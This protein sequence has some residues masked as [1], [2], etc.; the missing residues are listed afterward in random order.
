MSHLEHVYGVI[1]A[2]GGGTRL[3]P[4]SRNASPKQFLKLMGKESMMQV[5]AARLTHLL[6][7]DHII[8]VTNK[9]Y[10]EEVRRELPE[11]PA[12]NIISEPEKRETALAMLVGT[13][14]AKRLD[15]EAV[16]INS[17]S[18]HVVVNQEEF[19]KV[20]EAAVENARDGQHLLTVGIQPTSPAT[21]FGYIRRGEKLHDSSNGVPVYKVDSFKE[22]PDADTAKQFVD[23]GEYYWNANMYVWSATALQAGF[24]KHMPELYQLTENLVNLDH[25]AFHAA[26][27]AIYEKSPSIAID[28]A[29]SEKA[30]NLL[31]FFFFFGWND[32]GDWKVVYELGQKD[33]SD[34]VVIN[35]GDGLPSISL[36]AHGNLVHSDGRLVSLIGVEDLL[37]IDT[38]E[39]LLIMPKSRSQEVKKIVEQLKKDGQ[40][41]YL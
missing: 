29:I 23:T 1:L 27:P 21:S 10:T 39:I 8:V 18:D 28:Y 13:L 3:W 7:W 40:Q 35:E 34:N 38:K 20:M 2:G 25:E 5:A 19:V 33:E 14:F 32:V 37:V 41:K 22:K 4:K 36:D 26:L 31:I 16:V 6:P 12:E 17:A 9:L 30:D 11:V 24:Q 15:P